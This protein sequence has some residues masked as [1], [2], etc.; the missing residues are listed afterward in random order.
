MGEYVMSCEE[1]R[2]I[3]EESNVRKVQTSLY[4]CLAI[5]EE[6]ELYGWGSNEAGELFLD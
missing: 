3:L 4:H 1:P 2:I 6:R 5:T